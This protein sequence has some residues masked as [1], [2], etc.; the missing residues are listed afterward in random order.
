MGLYVYVDKT[1]ISPPKGVEFH[2]SQNYKL[3]PFLLIT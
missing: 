1:N 3:K 2:L